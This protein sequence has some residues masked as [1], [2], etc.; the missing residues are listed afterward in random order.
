MDERLEIEFMMISLESV[1]WIIEH[2]ER[3]ARLEN[4]KTGLSQNCRGREDDH[5]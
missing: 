1:E 3:H 5:W 4:D 2:T